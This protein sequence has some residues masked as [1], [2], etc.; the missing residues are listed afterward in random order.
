MYLS[1]IG[2]WFLTCQACGHVGLAQVDKGM[3]QEA[4]MEQ[5]D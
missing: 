1:P 2:L 5:P 3:G 4:Q